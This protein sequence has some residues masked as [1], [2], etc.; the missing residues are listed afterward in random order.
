MIKEKCYEIE[1]ETIDQFEGTICKYKVLAYTTDNE[2]AFY[3]DAYGLE[4]CVYLSDHPEK[5][6]IIK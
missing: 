5:K 3:N 1:I 2:F 6:E 4:N